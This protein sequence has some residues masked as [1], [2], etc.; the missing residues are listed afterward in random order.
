LTTTPQ[1]THNLGAGFRESIKNAMCLR[2]CQG[3]AAAIDSTSKV[4]R[5]LSGRVK[6]WETTRGVTGQPGISIGVIHQG[7]EV[8]EQNFGVLDVSTERAPDRHT[9]YCIA[10]LSKAFMAASLDLLVREGKVTW[11]S[12]IHSVIPGFRHSQKPAE[13]GEMMLRDI[14]SHRTSL[15]SLDEMTHGLDGRIL[16]DKKGVAKV[17][18]VMPVKHDLRSNFTTTVCTNWSVALRKLRRAVP[19]ETIPNR[20]ISTIPNRSISLTLWA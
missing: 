15:L 3:S 5:L 11:D 10:S 13:F 12:I 8:F 17:C 9:L 18:N 7:N 6:T 20:S 16:I 4:Q 14:C 1:T 2:S 19:T